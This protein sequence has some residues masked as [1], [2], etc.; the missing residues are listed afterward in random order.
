MDSSPRPHRK[1]SILQIA[2]AKNP[3]KIEAESKVILAG[4]DT[5]LTEQ[6][7]PFQR[8]RFEESQSG[9]VV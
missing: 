6:S 5:D 8:A 9:R 3:L 4:V 1:C 2:N 7:N